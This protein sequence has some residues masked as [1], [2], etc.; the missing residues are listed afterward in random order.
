MRR[1]LDLSR[2]AGAGIFSRPVGCGAMPTLPFAKGDQKTL[3][4][5]RVIN[6]LENDEALVGADV[7]TALALKEGAKLT[8]FGQPFQVTAV[9]PQPRSSHQK[10]R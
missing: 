9:L 2:Q 3:V 8:L 5:Q 10:L 4:R 6:N 1:L 7:A